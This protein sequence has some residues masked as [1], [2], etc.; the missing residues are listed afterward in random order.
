MATRDNAGESDVRMI[1]MKEQLVG[2]T[3]KYC[4]VFFDLDHTLWDY[5][6]NSCDT[7]KELHNTYELSTRGIT[8][9]QLFLNQFRTVNNELWDLFDTGRIASDVIRKERFQRILGHFGVRDE[10][11]DRDLSADYLDQCPRKGQLMPYAIDV[12]DYLA[13]RYRLAVITNGFDEIQ[14][15]KLAAGN[16]HK[17]FNHIIT[18]QTA[19]H[20]KP[21]REIFEYALQHNETQCHE[22]IMIGD[23]LITDIGGAKGANIDAVFFNA[24]QRVHNEELDFEITSLLELKSIL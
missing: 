23:N 15:L 9:V 14:Q 4:T 16:L 1:D 18:S 6:T 13:G 24:E 22:A 17:Y 21:A 5:E 7:L 10:K 11:L 2:K 3:K 20:R 12:L 8:D 19:G